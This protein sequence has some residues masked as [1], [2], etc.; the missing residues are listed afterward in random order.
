[1]TTNEQ[2]GITLI[3]IFTVTPEKQHS[4]A[5]KVAHIYKTFVHNQ[6][7]F[8]SAKIQKS[9][10][11]TRV[12]AVAQWESQDF[13]TRMQQN[14]DFQNLVKILDSDIIGAE[15]HIYEVI[16]SVAS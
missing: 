8:I 9:L 14:S 2:D 5:D 6:P 10:D 11:G 12:A 4:A 3:N 7:G 15:A 13:L 16:D 1:M